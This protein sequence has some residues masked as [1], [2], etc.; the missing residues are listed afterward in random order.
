MGLLSK[1]TKSAVAKKAVDEARKPQNQQK[2]K[3]AFAKFSGKGKG[4]GRP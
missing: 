3:D 4:T 2:M 1:I